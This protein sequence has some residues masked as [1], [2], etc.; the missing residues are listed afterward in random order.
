MKGMIAV[1]SAAYKEAIQLALV[2]S[3]SATVAVVAVVAVVIV[4]IRVCAGFNNWPKSHDRG[5]P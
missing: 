2:D 1:F 4:G 3:I 5:G